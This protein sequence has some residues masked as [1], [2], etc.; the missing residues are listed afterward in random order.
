M[1]PPQAAIITPYYKED[2]ATLERCC[3]SVREQSHHNVVHYLI[4]DGFPQAALAEA[5]GRVRHITLP[6]GHNDNGN[7]PRGVGALCALN[8]GADV[9]CFLDADNFYGPE[10]VASV[11]KTFAEHRCDAV[12]S[13]RYI[14]PKGHPDKLMLSPEDEA[15]ALVDTSCISLAKSAAFLFPAWALI[16]RSLSTVCDLVFLFL[17]RH[18]QLK[19]TWNR[20]FTVY[21]ESNYS[22]TFEHF[23]LPVPEQTH[24]IVLKNVLSEDA[25][26]ELFQRMHLT[27]K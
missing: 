6:L 26:K 14:F 21:F 10:H 8:E 11:L 25:R 23:N 22:G 9:V 4:A 2:A 1:K 24:D 3:A 17:I 15:Q 20:E 16:P 12:F 7:T 5:K 18:H 27:E 19:Y 13:S